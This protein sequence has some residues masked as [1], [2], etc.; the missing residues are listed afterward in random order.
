MTAPFGHARITGPLVGFALALGSGHALGAG[1]YLNESSASGLGNAFAGGAAAADDAT[2]MWSNVAGISRIGS[3]QAVGVIHLITPSI[4]FSNGFSA[5]AAQQ[6]LGGDGG[7]AGGLNVVPNLYLVMPTTRQWSLGLGISSPFGLV[8]EYDD[9]WIGRFQAI[10]SDI[11]TLNINPG[12]SYKVADNLALGVGVD[13]QRILATFTSRANYSAALLS[14]AAGP[15]FNITPG[16]ANYNAIAQATPRLESGVQVK[17]SDNAWGWNLGLLWDIDKSRRV[18]VHYR[19]SIRYDVAGSA[20]FTNPT[21]VVPAPL[22]PTVGLLANGVNT[23]ALFDSAVTAK[24]KLPPIFN[25]SYFGAVNDRW[26]VMADA[27]W[28]GWSTVKDLTFVRSNGATLQSTPENFK[29]VW[30][31]SVGANYHY[32]DKWLFRGGLAFDQS[33]VEAVDRT[34]RLPDGDRTWLT[35]GAQYKF[36][37]KLQVEFGAGYVWVKNGS[38]NKSGDPPNVLANGLLNGNYK[39]GNTVIL[40]A[41]AVYAF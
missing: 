17:G 14:A 28:M 22:A 15:P 7:D 11:M 32:D 21:P 2:T 36:D 1:F 24:V 6:A 39:N 9:G 13:F 31:I 40:S 5:P 26:D 29:D 23:L 30:K 3:N 20:T 4:K 34:P 33:P 16:S 38:I 35:A 8:T 18:G 27:Q 37:R 19:S 10:K 41:Q 12:A 25:L